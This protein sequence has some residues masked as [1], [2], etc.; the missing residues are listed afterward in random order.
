[1]QHTLSNYLVFRKQAR[2]FLVRNSG[3]FSVPGRMFIFANRLGPCSIV[4]ERYGFLI[5]LPYISDRV[6]R[7]FAILVCHTTTCVRKQGLLSCLTVCH[8]S[9][10]VQV[11]FI[12]LRWLIAK[13]RVSFD[14]TLQM[15]V[16]LLIPRELRGSTE[17]IFSPCAGRFDF[18]I[19]AY[20]FVSERRCTSN[21]TNV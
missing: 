14:V 20:V 8:V 10:V 13:R 18:D 16:T 1:M 3:R 2:S 6:F 17:T 12:W 9:H 19:L 11:G 4:G 7:Q 21:C 5:S 15:E